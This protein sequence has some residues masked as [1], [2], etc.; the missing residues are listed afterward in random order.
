MKAEDLSVCRKGEKKKKSGWVLRPTGA[1]IA[2]VGTALRGATQFSLLQSSS[3]QPRAC[4]GTP[5]G[6]AKVMRDPTMKYADVCDIAK[7]F[8]L[9]AKVAHTS[10]SMPTFCVS[11]FPAQLQCC[12]KSR[13]LKPLLSGEIK[14]TTHVAKP[15]FFLR[16]R[17]G[18]AKGRKRGVSRRDFW[19][20]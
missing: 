11:G 10:I 9:A 13:L 8:T 4:R 16:C 6:L 1:G 20:P 7:Q 18:L 14:C 17:Q 12:V 5:S 19:I 15:P 2:T 3:S